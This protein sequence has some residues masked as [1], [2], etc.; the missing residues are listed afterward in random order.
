MHLVVVWIYVCGVS[1][2]SDD[3]DALKMKKKIMKRLTK[4]SVTREEM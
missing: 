4:K 1:I 3:D 2:W